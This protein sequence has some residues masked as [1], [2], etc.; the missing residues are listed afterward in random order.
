MP[1]VKRGVIARAAHKKV[2]KAAKAAPKPKAPK[3]PA[4]AATAE[5]EEKK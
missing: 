5:G 4:E 2:I 3:P 1:R